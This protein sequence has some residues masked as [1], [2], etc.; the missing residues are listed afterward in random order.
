M[1]I[2]RICELALILGVALGLSS[3]FLRLARGDDSDS[4]AQM[5]PNRMQINPQKSQEPPVHVIGSPNQQGAPGAALSP[6]AGS[7]MG[8]GIQI[9]FGSSTPP[10][11][12]APALKKKKKKTAA[13]A[14]DGQ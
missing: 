8:F 1:A 4:Q 10:A 14:P 3:T 12:Q 11:P 2:R 7:Q 5:F 9:P 13:P 6:N